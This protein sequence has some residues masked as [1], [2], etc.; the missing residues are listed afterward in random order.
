[1]AYNAHGQNV[2]YSH[3][4][5]KWLAEITT[6]FISLGGAMVS[7][8]KLAHTI[9]ENALA[10]INGSLKVVSFGVRKAMEMTPNNALKALTSFAGT[11]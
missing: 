6:E 7:Q 11:G 2:A 9:T 1:M 8:K 3:S 5:Q 10:C 4:K